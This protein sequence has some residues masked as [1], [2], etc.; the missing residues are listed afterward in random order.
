MNI[1]WD[2][3][4]KNVHVSILDYVPEAL[5]QFQHMPPTK[6]QHQP[7]PHIK[8]TYG[9]TKQYAET[10]DTPPPLSKEDKKYVQEVVVLSRLLALRNTACGVY[11]GRS[12]LSICD[13]K[14]IMDLIWFKVKKQLKRERVCI[15]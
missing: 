9:A 3:I 11:K 10:I 8:S 5:I 4:N 7:Y 15:A 6:P 2:Y 1:D 14:L 12:R 13:E